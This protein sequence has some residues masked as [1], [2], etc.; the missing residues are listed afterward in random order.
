MKIKLENHNISLSELGTVIIIACTVLLGACSPSAE[1]D[2]ND[3]VEVLLRVA[4]VAKDTGNLRSSVNVLRRAHRIDPEELEPVL[5]LADTLREL[6]HYSKAAKYYKK[7]LRLDPGNFKAMRGLGASH[8]ALNEPIQGLQQFKNILDEHPKDPYA[9]NGVGVLLDLNRSHTQ[10]QQC[11]MEGLRHEPDDSGLNNNMG[12][13]LALSNDY[14]SSLEFLDIASLEA[15]DGMRSKR[16]LDHIQSLVEKLNTKG[17]RESEKQRIQNELYSALS[18]YKSYSSEA[19]KSAIKVAKDYC[20]TR[21]VRQQD[22]T[23]TAKQ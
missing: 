17:L 16:N 6:G 3:Q 8:I 11:Y 22:R 9:L 15:A 4:R 14:E 19:K 20:V 13:S 21:I 2:P 10:A 7:A 23:S 5:N 1:F 12:L 18:P